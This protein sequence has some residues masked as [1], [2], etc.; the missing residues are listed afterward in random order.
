MDMQTVTFSTGPR[1]ARTILQGFKNYTTL[2]FKNDNQKFTIPY[3]ALFYEFRENYK[4]FQI[5]CL[6]LQY[7]ISYVYIARTLALTFIIF[8]HIYKA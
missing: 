7:H 6:K 3:N 4:N 8:C 5:F 2:P 1:S